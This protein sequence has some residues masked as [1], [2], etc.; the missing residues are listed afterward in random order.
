MKV[1]FRLH[2]GGNGVGVTL[3]VYVTVGVF[4]LVA[5][6]VGVTVRVAVAVRVGVKVG[7]SVHAAEI[8]V[9]AEV[10]CVLSASED[11]A[12]PV[13]RI[14]A[15]KRFTINFQCVILLGLLAVVCVFT[16]IMLPP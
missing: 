13:T 7:V 15:N 12:Q 3:G 5:V 1:E 4:V 2:R 8:T 10:V 14:A 6:A 11:G 16:A 9:C